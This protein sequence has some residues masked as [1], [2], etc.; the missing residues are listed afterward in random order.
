MD[1]T[2]RPSLA[3]PS[4]ASC[5]AWCSSS[6]AYDLEYRDRFPRRPASVELRRCLWSQLLAGSPLESEWPPCAWCCCWRRQYSCWWS[7]TRLN[8]AGF[9]AR[10]PSQAAPHRRGHA[11]NGLWPP[12]QQRRLAARSA[13]TASAARVVKLCRNVPA[14]GDS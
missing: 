4:V 7:P 10:P 12:I 6:F 5:R 11:R 1:E 2:Y 8:C 9:P 3:W 13:G 14:P